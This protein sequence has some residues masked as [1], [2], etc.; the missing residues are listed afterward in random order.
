MFKRIAIKAYRLVFQQETINF[1][2][3]VL[4][5]N[6]RDRGGIQYRDP[7]YWAEL[8]CPIYQEIVDKFQPTIF[9]DIGANYGFTSLVHLT[10]NPNCQL[11]L[12][13]PSPLLIPYLKKNLQQNGYENFIIINAICSEQETID[14]QFSLNPYSSQDNRVIGLTG[15]KSI[16]VDS[17]TINHLLKDASLQDKIYIKIDTQGFEEKVFKG[18]AKFFNK[19]INWLIKTEFAPQWLKS[20]GTNP[21]KFLEHLIQQYMVIELPKRTRFKGDSLKSLIQYPLEIQ[22]CDRFIKYIESL[23]KGNGWCDL[24]VFPRDVNYWLNYLS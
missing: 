6:N 14:S 15:W 21:Q 5:I 2:S 24:L 4:T 16:Q 20:Q 12:V 3:F 18:G 8:T 9:L 13:E 17:T 10:K 19:N 23:A 11:L 7:N 22:E 1:G